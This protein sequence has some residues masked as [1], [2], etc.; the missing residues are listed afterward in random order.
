MGYYQEAYDEEYA[1]IARALDVAADRAKRRIL[2][3]VRIFPNAQAA[4]KRM[5]H[6][7]PGPGQTYALQARQAKAALRNQEPAV[8]IEIRWCPYER[9]RGSPRTGWRMDRRSRQPASRTTT[10]S[11]G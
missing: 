4:I 10:A 3:R 8:E 2:G 9:T 7:E 11:S 1:A 6:D 5:T